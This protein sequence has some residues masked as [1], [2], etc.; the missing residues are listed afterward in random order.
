MKLYPY[1]Q[2]GVS[3]LQ[4]R[5]SA[6]LWLDMGLGKTAT[7]LSALTADHLPALVV[8]PPRVANITWPEETETW[9]P[10][11]RI[12]P[13]SGP[14]ARR[15]E[16]WREPADVYAVSRELMAEAVKA[17][18]KWRTLIID[19]ASGF[20]DRSTK[21]WRAAR[22]IA[23]MDSC[24]HVWELTGTPSPNGYLDLWAQV[25]LL[26]GG[27]RLGRTLTAYRD[28]YFIPAGRLP[29]GV[30][31]GWAAREGA[32]DRINELLEDIA[33]SMSTE[34]R[35]ELPEQ[36][37]NIVPVDLTPA[38]VRAYK[39]MKYKMVADLTLL[40]GVTHSAQTAA[41]VSNRLSQIAAGFIYDD[42]GGS[43]DILHKAKVDA[44]GEVLA[45][46]GSPVLC[47]YRYRAE[48]DLIQRAYP[49]ARSIDSPETIK[50]WNSGSI[51]LLLAHPASAGHGLNLQRGG[52][53]IVWTSLPWS[54][55]LWQQANKRLHRQGQQ[56][57]VMVHV[58]EARGTIDGSILAVLNQKA[59]AQTA[60]MNHLE[61]LI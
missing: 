16:L 11:L 57:T 46:T 4:S 6:A 35:V 12:Q 48:R 2:A 52:H 60:L 9:R 36:V 44:L 23:R 32:Q 25:Y 30:I 14:P 1:Q 18:P 19:E 55:E 41:T 40:G 17:G 8:A 34:G 37:M 42:D 39:D 49:F 50:A 59:D 61:S 45:E 31:T 5:P 38:A 26:D 51:P 24:E 54:L 33:M 47:F 58:L 22:A 15:R 3:F 20:K 43:Y 28:R 29:S 10:D 7:S 27:A 53:T 21:R 13:V 56:S